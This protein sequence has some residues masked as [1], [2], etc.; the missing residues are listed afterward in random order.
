[1]PA[2]GPA[3]PSAI[4]PGVALETQPNVVLGGRVFVGPQLPE[5]VGVT[6][7]QGKSGYIAT[8]K[9]CYPLLSPLLMASFAAELHVDGTV[10]PLTNCAFGVQQ[11]THQ[12]G[13]VS[14]R[15]RYEPVALVLDVPNSEVL[16][17]WANAPHK[18][19]PATI[20]FRNAA[21]GSP[22]ES[23]HLKAAYLLRSVPRSLCSRR[24]AG[25]SISGFPDAI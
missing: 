22:I 5:E 16:F 10:F 8:D 2:G 6:R 4:E 25:R 11:A 17:A 7:Q 23:L 3:S 21:G 14:T 12:R 18:R 15:V 24:R 9:Y 1:M 13:R 20:L 19:L